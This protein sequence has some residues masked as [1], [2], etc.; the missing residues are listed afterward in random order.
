MGM[1]LLDR[2]KRNKWIDF[3]Y[4]IG[5]ILFFLYY[6]HVLVVYFPYPDTPYRELTWYW[7]AGAAVTTVLGKRWK[8]GIFWVMAALL[9]MMWLRVAIE[10]PDF[11]EKNT[12]MRFLTGFIFV[13]FVAAGI[14]AVL[15]EN[16]LKAFLKALATL[17]I[18]ATVIFCAFG[19]YA[20]VT[21]THIY[22]FSSKH[23]WY[24]GFFGF[25]QGRL[26]L[27]HMCT[28][29]GAILSFSVM[30]SIWC[31]HVNKNRTVKILFALTVP[32]F[33]FT[34]GLTDCRTAFITVGFVLGACACVFL[35]HKLQNHPKYLRGKQL[36]G[37][38]ILTIALCLAMG[39]VILVGTVLAIRESSRTFNYISEHGLLNAAE[40][41]EHNGII[42]IP[43][44]GTGQVAYRDIFRGDINSSLSGRVAIWKAAFEAIRKDPSILYKGL[45]V[46]RHMKTV[47]PEQPHCHNVLIE[48]L[49]TGGIP[50]LALFLAILIPFFIRAFRL[51]FRPGIDMWKRLIPILPM[52]VLMGDMVT[53][54][55]W[56]KDAISAFF[57]LLL[58]ATVT[59]GSKKALGIL[60]A[61]AEE[62]G[63][64]PKQAKKKRAFR[65][66]RNV[67]ITL[68]LAA[69][70]FVGSGL[71]EWLFSRDLDN[72]TARVMVF[73]GLD[74][75]PDTRIK[76]YV[77]DDYTE[78]EMN[79]I[80][81]TA[82]KH[83]GSKHISLLTPGGLETWGTENAAKFDWLLIYESDNAI[84]FWLE[85][86]GW[87]AKFGTAVR[88]SDFVEA[89]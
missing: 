40:A 49:I 44:D 21:N 6:L 66:V 18:L 75:D 65:I 43:V 78:E 3:G 62:A 70:V 4:G 28:V 35:Y 10:T 29:S 61:G 25:Y 67:I 55:T 85:D 38:K 82:K 86:R 54:S 22:N 74:K 57:Y 77:A 53:C 89:E 15:K 9:G 11:M 50:S 1:S 71:A 56:P 60:P 58:G 87:T 73:N 84:R 5:M 80:R 76:I 12:V 32:L 81:K 69:T 64:A 45:S 41:E 16:R 68:L 2:E 17:W 51:F 27:L 30:L 46:Y 37:R 23:H 52:S 36:Y 14:P 8:D 48:F 88:V 83:L 63:D 47:Y 20:A 33:L 26:S 42:A 34:L 59:L 7:V 79:Q 72:W 39:A 31:C 13:F 24:K 19:I